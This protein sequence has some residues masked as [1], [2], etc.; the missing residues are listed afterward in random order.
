MTS[1]V[2]MTGALFESIELTKGFMPDQTANSLGGGIN[3]K[4]RSPL[5]MSEK[6]RT[7]YNVAARWAP[8]FLEHGRERLQHPI[9][10]LF[11]YSYQEAFDVLGGSRNL[12]IRAAVFY[13]ENVNEGP[14]EVYFYQ[15]TATS[16]AY[17]Y[18]YRTRS[19]INNRHITTANVKAEYRAS[20]A[21]KYN[22]SLVYNV[23]SEPYNHSTQLQFATNQAVATIGPDGTPT[24]TG[25]ILPGYTNTRTEVRA[26]PASSLNIQTNR[27][28][29]I[30]KSPSVQFTGEHKIER[31]DVDYKLAHTSI[32]IDR[33]SGKEGDGGLL[34]LQV[35]NIG[36][37]IDNSDPSSP[38]FTQTSGPSIYNPASYTASLRHTN[39]DEIE[40][41]RAY[42]VDFNAAYRFSQAR[43]LTLKSGFAFERRENDRVSRN[44]RQWNRV[45]GAPPLPNQPIM[46]TPF[47]ERQGGR[48]PVIDP[49][50]TSKELANPA[51]WQEDVYYNE[52]Q[53]L[54]QTKYFA[55]QVFGGYTMLRGNVGHL[56]FLGGVRVEDTV[57]TTR[58]NVSRVPATAA[59]IPDPVARARY[60]W[61]TEV[62]DKGGYTRSFPSAHLTYDITKDLKARASWSTGFGRPNPNDLTPNA[63]IN[64]TARSV[65]VANPGLGPQ[66]S[67]NVDLN[68]GYYIQPAGLLTLGYFTKSI[69]D[70]ILTT[71]AGTVPSGAGNGFGGDYV[72]YDVFTRSNAGTAKVK[73]WEL[74]YRQ[75]L[76]FLPGALKDSRSRAT[77][78]GFRPLEILAARH[79]DRTSEVPEFV[80]QVVNL[81]VAYNYRRFGTRITYNYTDHWLVTDSPTPAL[82]IYQGRTG[83]RD[84]KLI[85]PNPTGRDL[86]R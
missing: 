7:S 79:P 8:S 82:R 61:S 33:G 16:P 49:L 54:S 52:A 47:D 72:G 73:G 80:P 74:D 85:L 17:I 38:K 64:N 32:H 83:N 2:G 84:A 26:V 69:K 40:R 45:S 60:D 28:S 65:T 13:S 46:V 10:P 68:V 71:Q 18:D 11:N 77:I 58:G 27:A 43:N 62:R 41:S 23:G 24:G 78:L 9:H 50:A 56:G 6:R 20:E 66:Y 15:N 44:S 5:S 81:S 35:P 86:L 55:E 57:V 19:M 75:Q 37:I 59:Q 21:S 51:L 53:R 22:L 34:T 3:L 63:T 30:S 29:F 39:Q 42:N 76:T 12:G 70:Y 31:W 67:T 48:I 25:G 1:Y 4:T 14:G 36:W